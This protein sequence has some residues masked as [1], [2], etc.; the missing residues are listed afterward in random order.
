MNTL[1]KNEV[2]YVKDEYDKMGFPSEIKKNKTMDMSVQ[3]QKNG[4]AMKVFCHK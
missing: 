4:I 3:Y 2:M 1:S